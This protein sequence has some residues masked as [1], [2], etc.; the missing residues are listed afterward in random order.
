VVAAADV[1]RNLELAEMPTRFRFAAGA[2]SMVEIAARLLVLDKMFAR[3]N[4]A[5]VKLR[6][7][8][9]TLDSVGPSN[10]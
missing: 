4:G 8:Q 9:A 7:L 2:R 3:P 1:A 5:V 10:L 6:F